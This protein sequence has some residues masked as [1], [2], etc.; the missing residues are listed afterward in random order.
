M[1]SSLSLNCLYLLS[2]GIKVWATRPSLCSA[3]DRTWCFMHAKQTFYQLNNI[4]IFFLIRQGF[5]Q[6]K[7][8]L[9][10]LC[11]QEQP[12]I[13]DPASSTSQML[14]LWAY[15]EPG[16]KCLEH[17][18]FKWLCSTCRKRRT[19][20]HVPNFLSSFHWNLLCQLISRSLI[21][22]PYL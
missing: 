14:G 1:Y 19:L 9:N 4:S 2:T 12:W 7:L 8:V 6:P 22:C 18:Y 17:F 11:S 16:R 20:D 13:C 5:M 15:A 3:G 21:F 10:S